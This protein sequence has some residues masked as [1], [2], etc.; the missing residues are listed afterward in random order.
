MASENELLIRLGVDASDAKKQI[1]EV[2][3]EL[4]SLQTQIK[5]NDDATSGYNK[6]HEGLNKQL[7]LQHKTLDA[8]NT[9]LISLFV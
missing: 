4:K 5:N 3:K 1:T 2:N 6:T 8:L 9:K 7:S